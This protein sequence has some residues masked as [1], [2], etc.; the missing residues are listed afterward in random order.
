MLQGDNK[1]SDIT[2]KNLSYSYASKKALDNISFSLEPS[3]YTA[4][5]GSNGSG[6]STLCRLICGLIEK[7]E[8]EITVAED[9]RLG[10]VF[11]SP[12]DQIV[13]SKVY[14][15]TSFGPQNLKLSSDEVEL[16]AIL[17]CFYQS[18]GACSIK[19]L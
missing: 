14:R 7:Q 18:Y 3:S 5:V 19:Y 15:D 11:Q 1:K 4:I 9:K 8:G 12:K 16:R 17:G 6:K 13:S 10:L 2:V